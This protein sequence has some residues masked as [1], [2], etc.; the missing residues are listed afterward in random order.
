MTLEGAFAQ[1]WVADDL[2]AEFPELSLRHTTVDARTGRSPSSVRERLRV[3]SNRFSG[4]R[5][6][7]LR[8]EPIPWAYRVFFRQVGI[9]PDDHRTPIEQLALDRMRDGAFVSHG[10]IYDA[11]MI[12]TV[13]TGVPVLAL[14]ADPIAGL[15]GLR[16][17]DDRE[18]LGGEGRVLASGQ[19]VI[20]DDERSLAVL[21]GDVAEDCH[22]SS[23]TRRVLLAAVAVKGVPAISVEEAL[24]AAS[25]T[26]TGAP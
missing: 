10:A 18:R 11:A 3:L 14:D 22:V 5:A 23:R 17:A 19:L 21:F 20:A 1:G 26:L 15:P 24:W 9:D 13:E 7:N 2:A 25:E 12:A 16:L 4:G 8:Q 6:V